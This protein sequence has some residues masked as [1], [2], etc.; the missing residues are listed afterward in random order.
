MI[1]DGD[2]VRAPKMVRMDKHILVSLEEVNRALMT[3]G[4][5]T[6]NRD[7]IAAHLRSVGAKEIEQDSL[8]MWTI[9]IAAWAAYEKSSSNLKIFKGA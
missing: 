8:P 1:N 7:A 9:P 5:P 6:L 3:T 4:V 2:W